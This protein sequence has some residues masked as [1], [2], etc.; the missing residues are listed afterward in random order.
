MQRILIVD[1]EQ[2]LLDELSEVLAEHGYEIDTALSGP[3]ALQKLETFQPH[4]ML[5]DIAMPGMDGLETLERAKEV[6]PDLGVIMV[7]AID[8]EHMARRAIG[9]GAFDYITKPFD[10]EHFIRSVLTRLIDSLD[11]VNNNANN[12]VDQGARPREGQAPDP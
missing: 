2:D 1:D 5:L 8:E 7:T 11:I 9:L 12:C 6:D 3:E 4:I 10:L